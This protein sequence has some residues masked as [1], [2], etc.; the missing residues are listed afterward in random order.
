VDEATRLKRKKALLIAGDV[1]TH[2]V[3]S[4]TLHTQTLHGHCTDTNTV[5]SHILYRHTHCTDTHTVQSRTHTNI[6][7]KIKC[8]YSTGIHDRWRVDRGRITG[9]ENEV[10]HK[11]D[12]RS[13]LHSYFQQSIFAVVIDNRF[14]LNFRM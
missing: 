13:L 10:H 6:Y 7:N 2:T 5:Q 4:H 14:F 3:Q 12:I 9:F 8:N 11:H 1:S